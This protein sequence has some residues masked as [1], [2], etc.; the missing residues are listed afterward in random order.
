[1]S[2]FKAKMYQIDF[3]LGCAPDP[4]GGTYSAPP[5]PIAGIKGGLLKG[6]RSREGKGGTGEEGGEDK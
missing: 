4:A 5:D 2:D 6:E 3:G 1:V